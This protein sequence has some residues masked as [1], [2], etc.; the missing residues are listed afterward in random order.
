LPF[1]S[2][3]TGQLFVS[4]RQI[5]SATASE[6][7]IEDAEGGNAIRGSKA[8][9]SQDDWRERAAGEEALGSLRAETAEETYSRSQRIWARRM[10]R[11]VSE[12][13]KES[14]RDVVVAEV[15]RSGVPEE[16]SETMREA[17]K[18]IS[19]KRERSMA[20]RS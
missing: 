20:E 10:A 19:G 18:E 11:V 1:S 16:T 3:F 6:E 8:E 4:L 13:L 2:D 5:G 12:N 15:S 17:W 14:S 9:G 7:P